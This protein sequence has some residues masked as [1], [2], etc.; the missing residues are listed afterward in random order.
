MET[1]SL[2]NDISVQVTGKIYYRFK[3]HDGQ[4]GRASKLYILVVFV[5]NWNERFKKY[6]RCV[7][8]TV[9]SSSISPRIRTPAIVLGSTGSQLR[10]TVKHFKASLDLK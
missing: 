9:R 10:R 2:L 7:I 1:D 8:I 6:P 5:I 3:M 4:I